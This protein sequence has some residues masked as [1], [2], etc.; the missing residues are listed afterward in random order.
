MDID[1]Q[2]RQDI[3]QWDTKTWGRALDF[4]M[5]SVEIQQNASSLELGGREGGLSLW[6]ALQGAQVICSDLEDVESTASPL[7][8]KY[9]LTGRIQYEQIDATKI[10]Y[11]N[12]FDIVV[13]KSILGGVGHH[14][15]IEK[16][17][18]AFSSIH[19]ALKPGG[20]LL[21]AENLIASPLHTLL[22]RKFIPWSAHWRYISISELKEFTSEFSEVSIKTSGILATFGRTN[23][24]R[25]FLA[26]LDRS[27]EAFLPVSWRYMAYGVAKKAI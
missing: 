21:F 12:K 10:P 19:R 5:K 27:I 24:Q 17:F 7:H 13:F 18:K 16:Q 25:N 15:Q 9:G 23:P 3:L 14:D 20:I 22:R 2:T 1:T 4:W 26:S 6:L 8:H 11:E